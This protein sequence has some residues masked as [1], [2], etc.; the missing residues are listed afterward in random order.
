MA[1]SA[2]DAVTQAI[3]RSK[4][5]LFPFKAEK[6]FAL[7]FTVFLAQCGESGGTPLQTPQ[8]PGLPTGPSGRG[9][10]STY[11]PGASSEIQKMI[12]DA[13]RALRADWALYVTLA[14]AGIVVIFGIWTFVL[15][16][17]SRAK[18]MFVES[19]IWDRVDISAQWS[20]AG[21]LGLSLF[22]F[23]A[24]LS[25]GGSLLMLLAIGGAVA[26]GLSDFEKG[27]FLG[28][29]A[30]LSYSIFGASSL[31]FGLPLL[32]TTLILDDFVVPLMIVRNARVAEAWG[33]C[34]R[35]VLSSHV[36]G[37]IF[38]YLLRVVLAFAIGLVTVVLACV[39]CC[40]M[41][42]PYIQTVLLLP[43]FVFSRAYPLYYLEQIGIS[44]FPPP[45]PR[46]AAYDE[47]RFPR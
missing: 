16:F 33:M 13:V 32:L 20:R 2:A 36:S 11:G 18:L 37:V 30:L 7:G 29:R 5:L 23:R 31:L 10:P 27:Q 19:V 35:E 17:S 42:I 15:W 4:Q 28:P 6:W 45:E 40:L 3:E 46:W 21:E 39:T 25:M 47:W 43:I 8:I 34:R 22:K 44:I 14:V 24:L 26:A 9:V 12:A 41:Y 38:F 1:G